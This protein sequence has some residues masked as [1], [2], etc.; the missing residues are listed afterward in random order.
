RRATAFAISVIN[1][2]ATI[3]LLINLLKDPNGDVR[4]WAA[5]AININKYD[6]SDIRGLFCGDAFQG[7]KKFFPPGGKNFSPGKFGPFP[8]RAVYKSYSVFETG[9]RGGR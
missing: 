7:G 3:P 9:D 6:N 8:K 4:N 1:D 2:K 5:F